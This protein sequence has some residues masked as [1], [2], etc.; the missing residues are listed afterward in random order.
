[1]DHSFGETQAIWFRKAYLLQEAGVTLDLGKWPAE[2]REWGG[3]R[4]QYEA[5]G[6][7]GR[8]GGVGVAGPVDEDCGVGV[9][10]GCVACNEKQDVEIKRLGS[11]V[12]LCIVYQIERMGEGIS[13][14]E[15]VH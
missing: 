13:V 9:A 5:D 3:R 11:R 12:A 8:N 2:R 10:A 4:W 6:E 7:C 15:A 14:Q 1:L